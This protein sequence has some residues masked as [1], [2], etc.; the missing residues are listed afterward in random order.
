MKNPVDRVLEERGVS[1]RELAVVAG[2]DVVRVRQFQA[3]DSKQLSG[4]LLETLAT[5]GYD[6]EQLKAEYT[7]WRQGLA[8]QMRAR[9]L[10][11]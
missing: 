2:V 9:V 5:M 6:R 3:G 8:A 11:Q 4:K 1:V 7:S 10:A